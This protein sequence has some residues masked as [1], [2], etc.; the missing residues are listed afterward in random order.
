M[1]V[2]LSE[3]SAQ[4]ITELRRHRRLDLGAHAVTVVLPE[5]IARR[6]TASPAYKKV[7]KPLLYGALR[8]VAGSPGQHA[9]DGGPLVLMP[10]VPPRPEDIDRDALRLSQ[11][12]AGIDW[13]ETIDLGRGVTTPGLVDYRPHLSRCGLPDSLR[14]LR[15]LEVGARDGF[16]AFEMERRGAG[17]VIAL[18]RTSLADVPV[19]RGFDDM[20][21]NHTM[22]GFDVARD[23]LDSRVIRVR[24]DV[25]AVSPDG[26]GMFDLIVVSEQLSKLRNPQLALEKLLRV[27]RGTLVLIERYAP[28]LERYGELALSEFVA[29]P[30]DPPAE[31]WSPNVN[32]LKAMLFM[33]GFE[34]VEEVARFGLWRTVDAVQLVVLKGTAASSPS[35][36]RRLLPSASG[37]GGS[38]G[39]TEIAGR[40]ERRVRLRSLEL[41]V[42]VSAATAQRVSRSRLYRR[43]VRPAI[44]RLAPQS[45]GSDAHAGNGAV[46]VTRAEESAPT[47]QRALIDRISAIE[48][49]HTIELGDGVVT[50]GFVDHRQQVRNYHFPPSLEGMRCLDVATFDGFWA[51]EMERRGAAEVVAI[52]VEHA[53]DLD[54]PLVILDDWRRVAGNRVMGAGFHVAH[55]I[56]GSKVRH[57]ICNIY[58]LS[59]ERLGTFDFVF[60]SDVLLHLRDPQ[61]ALERIAS[62]CRGMLL[63][64]DV[65]LPA[66]DCLPEDVSQY[67]QWRPGSYYWWHPSANTLKRM[68]AVAGLQSIEEV[69][70]FALSAGGGESAKVVLTGK[71]RGAAS[72]QAQQAGS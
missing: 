63:V 42:E 59:P 3:E 6:V 72:A 43:V 1:N 36:K 41:R 71:A 57:E 66:L 17:E 10:A 31:W 60:V 45:R 2:L 48:W 9:G 14:G 4:P 56:L 62:V 55:E 20:R 46:P 15:C 21:R 67:V 28:K 11:R 61:L 58:D 34:P 64:A 37:D 39:S 27:C 13:Y 29:R 16:W 38:N 19:E 53:T 47:P 12:L 25:Y 70:R 68:M 51:F 52:D 7:L 26:I 35:I 5:S 69:A 22:T 65:F 50:P 32:T 44:D 33:A 23:V 30:G 18:E 40:R 49:Y 8:L 24:C 54:I